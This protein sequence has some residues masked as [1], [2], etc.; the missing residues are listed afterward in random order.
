[1]T[2][3]ELAKCKNLHLAVG[4]RYI[5]D[6]SRFAARFPWWW[7]GVAIAALAV[8]ALSF[9]VARDIALGSA[10]QDASAAA[11]LQ[12]ALLDSEIARFRLLPLALADDRDITRAVAGDVAVL[13]ALD[14]KLEALARATGAAAIYVVGIGGEA[15]AASNYRSPQSFVGASYRFRRYVQDALRS[16][17]GS[18]FAIGTVSRQ[19]GLYLR[20]GPPAAGS[21]SSSWCSTGSRRRGARRA[22]SASSPT[23]P[24]WCWSAAAPRG[25][26]PRHGRSTRISRHGRGPTH[27][28]ATR[29]CRSFRCA[30]TTWCGA[31]GNAPI[32]P[33]PC[34]FASP[35]GS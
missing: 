18:Q 25:A 24:G 3:S 10:R 19:P 31:S 7:P 23:R 33:A 1:M 30:V 29:R 16:G 4:V 28:A 22:A 8:A 21:S 9:V 27:C 34:P 5:V 2:H 11:R 13:P 14:R 20:G 15:I 26:S 12:A 6:M 32:W 35:A 17:S